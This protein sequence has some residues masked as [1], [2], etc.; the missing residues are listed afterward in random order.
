MRQQQDLQDNDDSVLVPRLQVNEQSSEVDHSL[1][2]SLASPLNH[3]NKPPSEQ[4]EPRHT[5]QVTFSDLE[6]RAGHEESYVSEHQ[7]QQPDEEL[8]SVDSQEKPLMEAFSDFVHA[9]RKRKRA[10]KEMLKYAAQS[11]AAWQRMEELGGPD[12][13]MEVNKP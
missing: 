1:R 5:K 12:L 2:G 13:V 8:G 7:S 11:R 9:T 4:K 6:P 3:F 10:E